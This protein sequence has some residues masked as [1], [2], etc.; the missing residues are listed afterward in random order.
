MDIDTT[1]QNGDVDHNSPPS[2]SQQPNDL[3]N[4]DPATRHAQEN[5]PNTT[6]EEE[7]PSSQPN[8]QPPTQP[9]GTQ[10]AI[11]NGDLGTQ[12]PPS[13]QGN[14][15]EEETIDPKESLEPF[16]WDDLEDRF[17]QKMEECQRQEADI[18]KE[19]REWCQV[20]SLCF[21]LPDSFNSLVYDAGLVFSM[22]ERGRRMVLFYCFS[23]GLF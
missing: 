16:E 8:S 5:Q 4:Q 23:I 14:P 2:Q 19:F 17:V 3:Q 22:Q 11:A 7:H 10:N 6:A 20:G 18:E 1:N 15:S 12:T 13:G 21:L 9:N